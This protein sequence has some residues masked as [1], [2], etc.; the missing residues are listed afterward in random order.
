MATSNIRLTKGQKETILQVVGM[1]SITDTE[2]LIQSISKQSPLEF[3]NRFNGQS[4]E[5]LARVMDSVLYTIFRQAQSCDLLV[6]GNG[7][8]NSYLKDALYDGLILQ[9]YNGK[10]GIYSKGTMQDLYG[11][12]IRSTDTLTSDLTNHAG[13]QI[14]TQIYTPQMELIWDYTSNSPAYILDK[15]KND[16]KWEAEQEQLIKQVAA[17]ILKEFTVTEKQEGGI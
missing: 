7:E 10:R 3:E 15:I 12:Y 11:Q 2:K 16:V 13:E 14:I 1:C 8:D 6:N 9:D 17:Q 5:G 4:T